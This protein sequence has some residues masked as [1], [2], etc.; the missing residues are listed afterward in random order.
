MRGGRL[1]WLG[2]GI[3]VGVASM[4]GVDVATSD[5]EKGRM[6]YEL[7]TYTALPG[8]LPAL[9]QRFRDHTMRLFEKHGMKNVLYTTPVD[10]DRSADTLV[11]LVA[12]PSLEAADRAW[13]AF[14]SD[15]DWK[16]AQ[17]ESEKDGKIVAKVERQYLVPTDYSPMK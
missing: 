13:A 3:V 15:P 7:R 8:R 17:A 9:H 6:V 14:R 2:A 4:A 5:G 1:G 16:K 11:Y 12:H 10:A